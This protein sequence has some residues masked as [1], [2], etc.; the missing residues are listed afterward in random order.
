MTRILLP[1]IVAAFVA[2]VANAN[3]T[4]KAA[5]KGNPA[6][7]Q[8]IATTVCAACHAADGNGTGPANPKIAGQHAEYLLKQMKNFKGA[9]GKQPERVNAIMNGM[10]AP[11]DEAQMRDLA[12]YFAA[13]KQSGEKAKS[14]ETIE[15][16][17]KLYRAGD[18]SKGLAACAACHGPAGAGIPSQYPRIQGQYAEYIEAQVKAF[19]D[20]TRANDP[21]KMMQMIAIKMTDPEIKA[22][23]DYIAGLR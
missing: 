1:L 10:I 2:N 3:E 16:G 20:G 9:D 8:A 13:Q 14:R 23:S 6:K 4:A 18:K 19:R 22:V 21:A 5:P 17:Q 15:A 11:Y 7:G 12:A